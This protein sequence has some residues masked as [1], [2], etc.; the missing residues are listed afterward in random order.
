MTILRS[1]HCDVVATDGRFHDEVID[2]V[3]SVL[4]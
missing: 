3:R 2:S 1:S 4:G